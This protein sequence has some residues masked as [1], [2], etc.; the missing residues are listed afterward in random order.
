MLKYVVDQMFAGLA[1]K[2]RAEGIDCQ[3]ATKLVRGTE[4]SSQKVKDAEIVQLLKRSGGVLT[5][6]TFDGDLA[7]Y[8]RVEDLPCIDVQDLVVTHVKTR[9]AKG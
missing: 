6:I 7:D 3:T 9:D 8:C 5:V 4:D 2:L 1:K